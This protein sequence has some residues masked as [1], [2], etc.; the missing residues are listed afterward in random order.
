MITEEQIAAARLAQ[1]FGGELMRVD[2]TTLNRS[3]NMPATRI[4]PKQILISGAGAQQA[5]KARE[6]QIEDQLHEQ[7][8]A[9]Y[10]EPPPPPPPPRVAEPTSQQVLA[11]VVVEEQLKEINKNLERI[12]CALENL[13]LS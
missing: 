7:A 4:D 6:K 3:G 1:M 10:P 8:K 9:A 13:K 5:V 2:E 12:A 11:P